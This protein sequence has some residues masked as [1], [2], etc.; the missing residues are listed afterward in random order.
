MRTEAEIMDDLRWV[1]E[2]LHDSQEHAQIV[3]L[4]EKQERLWKE[5]AAVK[6]AAALTQEGR[7]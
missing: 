6:E 2:R 4:E 1:G 7:G 3:R 5:L